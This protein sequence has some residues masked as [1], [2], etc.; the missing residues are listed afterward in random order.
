MGR[1]MTIK[2]PPTPP[3]IAMYRPP[4]APLPPVDW[5][6]PVRAALAWCIAGW[7]LLIGFCLLYGVWNIMRAEGQHP[8]LTSSN[9]AAVAGAVMG[10]IV[11][12]LF[13]GLI[14]AAAA[15][16]AFII[17]VMVGKGKK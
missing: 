8:A 13:W 12:L 15:V 5:C 1:V 7:T 3:I 16:P 17:W 2:A 11:A 10:F 14:W 6:E 4:R 9:D